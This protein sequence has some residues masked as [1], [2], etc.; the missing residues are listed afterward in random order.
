MKKFAVILILVLLLSGCATRRAPVTQVVTGIQIEFLRPEGVLTRTYSQQE[1]IQSILNYLR[2]IRPFGPIIP[3]NT[4]EITCRF[5]LRYS[6]GPDSIFVQQGYDYLRRDDGEWQQIDGTQA[7][8]LYPM[9][10]LLP[11]DA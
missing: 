8:L 5:T 7:Q 6:H 4:H 10:L 1:S 3:E 9:L 11:S 2:I